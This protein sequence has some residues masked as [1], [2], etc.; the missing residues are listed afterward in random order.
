MTANTLN[1]DNATQKNQSKS[2]SIK[3]NNQWTTEDQVANASDE[4]A[5]FEMQL[6]GKLNALKQPRPG[7]ASRS[8][9]KNPA[10]VARRN[11]RE[12]R[13]IK[14]VN[15]AFDEL[16]QHV[17][18]GDRNRKKISKVKRMKLF[19]KLIGLIVA[20]MRIQSDPLLDTPREFK[21]ICS[22]V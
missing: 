6:S 18:H 9:G 22:S 10:S 17:P 1:A 5:T 7:P 4:N 2:F 11:A 13:R 3:Y 14:N 21:V 15:S 12:R 8:G 20:T 16:R 19:C